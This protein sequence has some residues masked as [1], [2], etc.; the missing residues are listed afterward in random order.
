VG[1]SAWSS[2]FVFRTARPTL[3]PVISGLVVSYVD[4]RQ[5]I[6]RWTTDVETT[7]ELELTTPSGPRVFRS[8]LF[9]RD[10][11]LEV[12]TLQAGTGYSFRVTVTNRTGQQA[13]DAKTFRTTNDVTPPS[14]VS[15]FRAVYNGVT[16]AVDLSWNNPTDPD[17]K[18]VVITRLSGVSG[19]ADTF[20]CMTLAG[21]CSDVSLVGSGPTFTY[22]A[23]AVDL[24]GN[25][26]SGALASVVVPRATVEPPVE[27]VPPTEET[28]EVT[29]PSEV[30]PPILRPTPTAGGETPVA[31]G[32]GAG[33]TPSGGEVS[34]TTDPV[35]PAA[36]T[37]TPDLPT[38][39]AAGGE[40]SLLLMPEFFL[41]EAVVASPDRSGIRSALLLRP[42]QLRLPITSLPTALRAA[43]VQTG[44][45]AIYQLAYRESLGAYVSDFLIEGAPGQIQTLRVQAVASDNRTWEGR[46]PFRL[47]A[48]GQV[49]DISDRNRST[50]V[51]GVTVEISSQALGGSILNVQTDVSG[52]YAA[53]L[54]RGAYR[55]KIS[56][57]G[58]R[59]YDETVQVETGI[60][61]KDI[62]LRRSVMGLSELIDPNASLAENVDHLVNE[63]A[64]VLEAVRQPEVQKVTESVVAPVVVV[65]TL[66]TTATAVTGFAAFNY[67]RF[68]FTQPLLLIRRRR[69]QSWGVVYNALSKQPVELA[70]VRLM[71]AGTNFALQTRITDAQGRFSFFVPPGSYTIQIQKPGYQFPSTYLKEA[72]IDVDFVDLYHGE[73]IEVKEPVTISPNIPLDPIVKEETPKAILRRQYWRKLQ[74]ALSISGIVIALAAIVISPSWPM[75]GFAVFQIATYA[76]F[77]RLAVPPAPQRWGIVY[78]ND[79][80]HPLTKAVVRIFDKKFNK[81][82]ETQITS[83]DGT[84]GF[85]AAK[86]VYYLTAEKPGYER[87]LS[88]DIDLTQAKD[89]YIDHR[90]TLKKGA[91]LVH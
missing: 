68:L 44:D 26:S 47:V 64:L 69:R 41:S 42:I 31:P 13:S 11:Q 53:I 51:A 59:S 17:F 24:V 77:R 45:G 21:R 18:H 1:N 87:Y 63:A 74:S 39:P 8:S 57:E 67:L 22:R 25:E 85:F 49:S 90:F 71:K 20:V 29:T 37:T 50:P 70:I 2:D 4:D 15:G 16:R 55:I 19:V 34:S 5:A 46:Y 36:A 58:F 78:D 76:L 66:G 75:I 61:A 89:T 82:L 14:N 60:L 84:Y 79:G 10:H 52:R 3:A 65:A 12:G 43:Q 54:A 9:A 56:K 83:K 62:Q 7:Y 32:E 91:Q 38:D 81:L 30:L 35:V 28:P 33:V 23:V 27:I 72:R 86:G 73:A 48:P 40:G 88:T 80:K 6:I